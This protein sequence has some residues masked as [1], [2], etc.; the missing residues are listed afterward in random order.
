MKL[1]LAFAALCLSAG[2]AR[3]D[4]AADVDKFN[5]WFDG[6]AD[7]AVADQNNCPKMG[8]DLNK[9]LDDNKAIVDAARKAMDS[10]E[11]IPGDAAQH[12]IE[13]NKRLSAAVKA[14]CSQEA[15]VVHA[16][17]RLP[18]RNKK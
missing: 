7:L 17:T 5:V 1:A 13:T 15:G 8:T 3:A 2:I 18:G 14:K 16:M 6:F 12:M 11:D 10:G 9:S 4:A